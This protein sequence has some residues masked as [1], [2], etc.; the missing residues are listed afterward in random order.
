M[1]VIC[2][3]HLYWAAFRKF[4]KKLDRSGL[5]VYE[6]FSLLGIQNRIMS[7]SLH[8]I[9]VIINAAGILL[10][11]LLLLGVIRRKS[12]ALIMTR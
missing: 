3:K 10:S 4:Q 1:T 7:Y 8:N 9:I 5:E 11:L 2:Q 6:F 12:P